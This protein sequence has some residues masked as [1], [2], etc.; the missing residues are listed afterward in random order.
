MR[1]IVNAH[2]V[3]RKY[4]MVSGHLP[5]YSTNKGFLQKNLTLTLSWS[6]CT[7]LNL[8]MK[9]KRKRYLLGKKTARWTS[10]HYPPGK[11]LWLGFPAPPQGKAAEQRVTE[12]RWAESGVLGD[13]RKWLRQTP[14]QSPT[15]GAVGLSSR[16]GWD[17]LPNSSL[18]SATSRFFHPLS[19]KK[20]KKKKRRERMGRVG[21][22]KWKP[23][24]TLFG[25]D[26]S[27]GEDD[28]TNLRRDFLLTI[29]YVWPFLHLLLWSPFSYISLFSFYLLKKKNVRSHTAHFPL[30]LFVRLKWPLK[31]SR[32]SESGHTSSLWR[33][34]RSILH[35]L[36]SHWCNSWH[37]WR[38]VCWLSC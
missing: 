11:F 22:P 1:P 35:Q 2:V 7:P 5:T 37:T 24:T 19:L 33:W 18:S 10:G 13:G 26:E 34:T 15:R 36:T 12:K 23:D 20:G 30:C 21:A 3:T 4:A 16:Q 17:K 31:T 8:Y 28:V 9:K 32:L 6:S 25:L 38:I 14:A 27:S 29:S